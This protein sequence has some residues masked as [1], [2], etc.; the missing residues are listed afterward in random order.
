MNISIVLN[1][2]T[3]GK[4]RKEKNSEMIPSHSLLYF[5]LSLQGIMQNI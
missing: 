2:E 1:Q 5:L 3:V 4:E